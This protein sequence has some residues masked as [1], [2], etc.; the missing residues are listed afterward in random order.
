MM[1]GP[2]SQ[3]RG[4]GVQQTRLMEVLTGSQNQYILPFFWQHGE[5]EHTLRKYMKV[6]HEANIGAVCVEARPHPDFAGPGWWRDLDIIMD[7]ARQRGMK[8]WVLDDAHFPTGQAAGRMADAP[9]R[10]CKQ[11]LAYNEVQVC[12]PLPQCTLA[13]SPFC[14]QLPRLQSRQMDLA[15]APRSNPR[16][17]H[18]NELFAVLAAKLSGKS[19]LCGNHLEGEVLDLSDQTEQG[20]LVWDVPE[21]MW[22]IF[23]VYKTRNGGGATNYINLLSKESCQV[24]IDAVYVPHYERY[25]A[26]FGKTF[27]G[28]FSDEPGVGNVLGFSS[29]VQIGTPHLQLP[30]SQQMQTAMGQRLGEG[31]RRLL[32]A[33]WAPL[34]EPAQTARVRVAYM[35]LATRLIQDNFGGQIGAW[36]RERGVEYIG[37]I[38]EDSDMSVR[39]G[40]SIGHYFRALWGQD[41]AGI[42]CIGNQ[43]Q[44]GG[45]N[46]NSLGFLGI[47]GDG[48]FF[49]YALGKLGSS[50][51]HIDPKKKGRA[52]CELFGASGWGAGTRFMS[53]LCNH[54]LSR[55]INR[56]VPHA[57][58]PKAFPDMDC[59]PHF[60]A[61]GENPLY[62]H[63]AQLMR[64]LNRMA[65]LLSDGVHH[66]QAALLYHAEIAWSG[67]NHTTFHGPARALMENQIDFDIIPADVFADWDAFEAN[68]DTLLRIGHES[69]RTL[70]I[71]GGDFV[72]E[73]VMSFAQQAVCKGFPVFFTGSP[74]GEQPQ[75]SIHCKTDDLPG[76]LKARGIHD[77]LLDSP[78][79]NL[80]VYHYQNTDEH[81]YLL[82]NEDAWQGFEGGLSFPV[83]GQPMRYE[84]MDNRLFRLSFEQRADGIHLNLKLAPCEATLIIITP[85]IEA[86]S[87]FMEEWK[88]I[89]QSAE[90]PGP[91]AVSFSHTKPYSTFGPSQIMQAPLSNVLLEQPGF[92]GLIRYETRFNLEGGHQVRGILFEDVHEGLELWCNGQYAGICISPPYRLQLTDLL[93]EGENTL[94]VQVATT[95]DA[96]V[97]ATQP[98]GP[99]GP[100][101]RVLAPSG[102]LGRVYLHH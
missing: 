72:P 29:D 75:G 20:R 8:V 10:L 48:E 35:D 47:Q 65:H 101:A 2:A 27:A 58:S 42:D 69:Y 68:F 95:L 41:M 54:F 14:R 67:G 36:C 91:W 17:F 44:A 86:Y 24:Q 84:A 19:D 25:Q 23:I 85:Q 92:S 59:P 63:F 28:F 32:P 13:V 81:L 56:F 50:L 12:G 6:I 18:D 82:F 53:Y 78:F 37:H 93:R 70:V 49:H 71:P 94:R 40:S 21:G 57:F 22:R 66:A 52:M 4:E 80:R 74:S 39:L 7:E 97:R 15:L 60:Y 3:K 51:A 45:E 73:A 38:I 90:I 89:Q 83:S 96:R 43:V 33:L 77:L 61:Q 99:F 76:L 64:Y 9:P 16:V 79:P 100:E 88:Q 87:A 62:P 34:G 11:Y 55:G 31:F 30:W 26:D 46:R 102:I 1:K 5:D 98:E